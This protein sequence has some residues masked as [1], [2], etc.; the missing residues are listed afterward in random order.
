MPVLSE[1]ESR[2]V[3]VGH[4]VGCVHLISLW[5]SSLRRSVL[6]L[7]PSHSRGLAL[8]AF[9][10]AHD[11]VEHRLFHRVD[12]H[13]VHRMRLGAAQVLEV[14]LQA[15]AHALLDVL[16]AHACSAGGWRR[17]PPAA[18]AC[19]SSG[20]RSASSSKKVDTARTC[21]SAVV[22]RVHRRA[23]GLAAGQRAHRP[24]DVLARGAHADVL[25][26][27]RVVVV[28]VLQQ[29]LPHLARGRRGGQRCRA[30]GSARSRGRSTAGPARRGRSSARRSRCAAAPAAP[31]A[32]NRCRR[33]RPPECAARP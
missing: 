14:L 30:A 7:M 22:Q 16:L 31:S 5:S 10:L 12:D 4:G 17:W 13:V 3:S 2:A 15:G 28:Q 32:A 25:A 19:G 20:W 9:G 24:A 6:R 18:A 23:E 29:P 1:T 26:V 33:W 8:V 11:D 27:Q 21:A